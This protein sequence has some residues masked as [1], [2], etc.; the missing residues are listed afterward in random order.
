MNK[1]RKKRNRYMTGED[2]DMFH[3]REQ[4]HRRD[5]EIPICDRHEDGA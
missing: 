3:E 1:Y 4:E 5:K 2:L